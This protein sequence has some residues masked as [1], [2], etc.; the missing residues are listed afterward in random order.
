MP[1]D[2]TYWNRVAT[3]M[4]RRATQLAEIVDEH[5]DAEWASGGWD[6]S[7]T[8]GRN[9]ARVALVAK[10]GDMYRRAGE[11]RRQAFDMVAPTPEG[12]A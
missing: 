3:D 8:A 9:A 2:A 4:E 11:H 7:E 10:V 12:A 1:L 5:L 6:D